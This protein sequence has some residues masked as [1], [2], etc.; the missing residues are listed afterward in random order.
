MAIQARTEFAAALN[1]LA[2]EKGIDVSVVVEAIE[3]A[4]LAA[5][6]KD[7]SLRNEEIPEDFESLEAEIDP[8]TGE[9]KIMRGKENITPPGFARIAAQTAKQV[10]MQR[11]NEAEKGAI[12]D[13]YGKKVGTVI[14]GTIQ[15]QEGTTYFVDLGRAEGILPISEQTRDEYY[16]MGQRLKFYIKEIREG[17]RGPEVVLSRADAELVKGLFAQEVPEVQAGSVVFRDIAREAG[18]RTKI[19]AISTQEGVDPVGSLVGQKGVRVST[20]MNELGEERIDIIPYSEDPARYIANALS[21]AKEVNVTVSE[22]DNEKLAKV[23]V[24]STQMSL[25]IGKGGQNVRLAAKLTGWKIDIEGLGDMKI[26]EKGD[27]SA[28]LGTRVKSEKLEKTEEKNDSTETQKEDEAQNELEK[29]VE[30]K[31]KPVESEEVKSVK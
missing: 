30:S 26:S 10:I 17:K 21:P 12:M 2:S 5:Y 23:K 9:I 29:V 7:L 28:T 19:S 13:E 24:P 14:S 11:L 16:H 31:E 4:A 25:A 22:K 27:P 15:R 18:N 6:R 1:Q 3:Q 20:V 8:V